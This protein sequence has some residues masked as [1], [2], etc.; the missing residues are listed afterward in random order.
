MIELTYP[1]EPFPA[2]SRGEDLPLIDTTGRVVGRAARRECHAGTEL[3]HP[4]VHLHLF[5]GAGRLYLQKRSM[6]K[7]VQPGRW[8]TAVGGHIDYGESVAAALVREAY[9]ELGLSHIRPQALF[10]YVWRSAVEAEMVCAF[11]AVCEEEI[12][13]D[14][15][16]ISA[17]RWWTR[18]ELE[19][20][21]GQAMLTPQLE[22][23]LPRLWLSPVAMR[24]MGSQS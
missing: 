3:L 13:I 19:E 20:A 8:D 16:E 1:A 15:K 4:V 14:P 5:D 17:G 22:Q 7:D 21:A 23:E 6:T 24:L 9:E 2:T 11:A 18:P 12:S 10:H